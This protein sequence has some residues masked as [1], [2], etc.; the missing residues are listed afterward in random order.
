MAVVVR[1]AIFSCPPL[2]AFVGSNGENK[3]FFESGKNVGQPYVYACF[4]KL[5]FGG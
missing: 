4:Q 2:L 5:G 3:T 1:W